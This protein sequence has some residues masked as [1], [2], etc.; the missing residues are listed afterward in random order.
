MESSPNDIIVTI[1]SRCKK[2]APCLA[3]ETES[4][5]IDVSRCQPCI[6]QL[7]EEYKERVLLQMLE[8]AKPK[9]K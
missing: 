6:Q 5:Y 7:F 4:E 8:A 3:N 2:E 9:K 1:C